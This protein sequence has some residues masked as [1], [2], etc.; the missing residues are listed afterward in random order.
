MKIDNQILGSTRDSRVGL[1]AWPSLRVRCSGDSPKRMVRQ[2]GDE[3]PG[4]VAAAA[5][6]FILVRFYGFRLWCSGLGGAS[7]VSTV[8]S[9]HHLIEE[10]WLAVDEVVHHED[11]IL[12]IVIRP[13]GNVAGFDPDRRD[14]GVVKLDAEEGQASIARRGRNETAE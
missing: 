1:K 12:A 13:R 3:L 10:L 6:H 9:H 14:A 7:I 4:L 5:A 8:K 11:V 2:N